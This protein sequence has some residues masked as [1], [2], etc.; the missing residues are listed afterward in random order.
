MAKKVNKQ[1]AYALGF[2]IA[3]ERKRR[4]WSA[5]AFAKRLG[6]SRACVSSWEVAI[7]SPTWA[8]LVDLATALRMPLSNLIRRVELEME[9]LN[10]D[11]AIEPAPAGQ[12]TEG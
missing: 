5:T 1:Y 8:N 11:A 10:N 6:V 9:A 3:R 2:T 12:D 4:G 7:S